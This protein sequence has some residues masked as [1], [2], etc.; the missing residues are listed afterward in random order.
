MFR[1]S[2]I[3]PLATPV[4]PPVYWRKARSSCES[5]T[6]SKA[7]P[8]PSASAVE[9]LIEPGRRNA[10]TIFFTCR[11]TKST[12]SPLIPRSSPTLVTTICRT[13]VFVTTSCTVCAKFS[14]TTITSAPESFN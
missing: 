6:R 10:G 2:S 12:I 1:C 13:L 14:T 11:S 8:R 3:A 5:G 7:L 9:S 4:V